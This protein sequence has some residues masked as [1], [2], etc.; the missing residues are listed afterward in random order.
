MTAEPFRMPGGTLFE[1]RAV[2]QPHP[3]AVIG[4]DAA[5][6]LPFDLE[7]VHPDGRVVIHGG[8]LSFYLIADS[9]TLDPTPGAIRWTAS[10][11]VSVNQLL[12]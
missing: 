12:A 1:L 4:F 10:R 5:D 3:L 7:R 11:T 2:A 8:C 9:M 6:R